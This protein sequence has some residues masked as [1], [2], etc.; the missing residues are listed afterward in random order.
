MWEAWQFLFLVTA[1]AVIPAVYR[2][3]SNRRR[4]TLPNRVPGVPIFGNTFQM[5]LKAPEQGPWAEKLAQQYG[6]M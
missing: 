1:L 5:P 6:E 4:Y 3:M 2:R